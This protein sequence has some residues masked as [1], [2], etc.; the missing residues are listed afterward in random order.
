MPE[1][2]AAPASATL[3]RPRGDRARWERRA[4]LVARVRDFFA[5]RG[6]LEV[7]TPLLGARGAMDPA[8][9]SFS[10]VGRGGRVRWLQTS[11]EYAM[12]RLLAAG[13]GPIFQIR[14]S[15]VSSPSKLAELMLR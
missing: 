1:G 7:E 3:W 2:P 15:T 13:S 9:E 10:T 4:G 14:S 8:I 11:P 12:K 6:V 5:A